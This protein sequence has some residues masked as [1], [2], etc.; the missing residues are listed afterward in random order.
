MYELPGLGA[1][2]RCSALVPST[3]ACGACAIRRRLWSRDPTKRSP[4]LALLMRPGMTGMSANLHG[5]VLV[6]RVLICF[7][8]TR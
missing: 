2:W 6:R 5:L 8:R 1:M 3:A 4:R 7:L